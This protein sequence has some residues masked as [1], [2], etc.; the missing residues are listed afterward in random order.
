MRSVVLFALAAAACT[1]ADPQPTARAEASLVH[2]TEHREAATC[3]E[4]TS[5]SPASPLETQM[6]VRVVWTIV[7]DRLRHGPGRPSDPEPIRMFA[8]SL[9][10]VVA[11][12]DPALAAMALVMIGNYTSHGCDFQDPCSVAVM[13]RYLA[14]LSDLAGFDPPFVSNVSRC[15]PRQ[16]I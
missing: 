5:A 13:V 11:S 16:E 2:A 7:R 9:A 4:P 15:F 10:E 6:N 14:K 3:P 1:H 12:Q 8:D